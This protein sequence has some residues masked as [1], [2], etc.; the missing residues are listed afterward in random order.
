LGA[1]WVFYS[2]L[3]GPAGKFPGNQIRFEGSSEN[4]KKYKFQ[5][6]PDDA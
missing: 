1:G 5:T 3:M 6:S 4:D 2:M